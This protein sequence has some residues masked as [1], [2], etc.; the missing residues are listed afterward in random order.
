[1]KK[2]SISFLLIGI[3]I[4][5][6]NYLVKAQTAN[7]TINVSGLKEI[8]GGI[9]LGLYNESASFPKPDLEFMVISILADSS[10]VTYTIPELPVGE[11]AIALYHDINSDKTCNKNWIGVPTESY[12]FSNN[13]RVIFS[14]PSFEKT[15]FNLNEDLAIN[16]KLKH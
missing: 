14:A 6:A 16:V 13:V 5:G 9:Q 7:L 11:Y 15:K 4:L 3:L 2:K 12:G 10:S 8:R 1:M